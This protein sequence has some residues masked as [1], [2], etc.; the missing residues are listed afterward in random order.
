MYAMYAMY[1]ML[2]TQFRYGVTYTIYPT[3]A[4][5]SLHVSYSLY[6]TFALILPVLNKNYL[7]LQILQG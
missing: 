6:L 1:A 7:R 2:C 4:A 3:C 5:L